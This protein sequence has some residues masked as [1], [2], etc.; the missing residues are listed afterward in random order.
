[1]LMKY[2]TFSFWGVFWVDASS[3]KTAE[4]CFS[5]VARIGQMEEKFECGLYWLSRQ[6][7]PWLLV[8]DG[9]NDT[10]FDYAQ[11]FPSGGMGHILVTSRNP[12]CKVHA[13]IGS[14]EFASLEENDAISLLLRSASVGDLSD[15]QLRGSARPIAKALGYLPLALIQA[16]AAIQQ[17][18]CSLEEYLDIFNLYKRKTFSTELQQGKSSYR[19]DIFTTFEVS[20]DKIRSFRTEE[21]K[22]ALEILHVM[23][24]LHFDQVPEALFERAWD[25]L[26]H[27]SELFDTLTDKV[28][29]VPGDLATVSSAYGGWL[30]FLAEGRLPQIFS[31]PGSKWDKLRFRKAIHVLRSYSLIFRNV[32][33]NNYSMHPMVQFWARERLRPKAQKLWGNM[34]S[35]LLAES[36][37]TNTKESKESDVVYRRLLM[38]HIDSCLKVDYCE[39]RQGLDFDDASLSQYAKF[40]AVYAECGRWIEAA[41]IQE[42]ILQNRRSTLDKDSLEAVDIMTDLARS[43]WNSSQGQKALKLQTALLELFNLKLGPDDPRTLQA[44][45]SLGRTHWLCGSTSQAD[46]LGRQSYEGLTKVVGADHPFTLSAMHNYGRARLHLSDSKMAQELLMEAWEGRSRLLGET[47]LDTLETMQDLGMSCLALKQI[48]EA[49]HLVSFVLDARKRILGQEHAHTLWSI[50]DLSKIYCAQGYASDAVSLLIPTREIAS[51]TLGTTHIGTIMTIFNLSQAYTQLHKFDQ[52]ETIL[53]ELLETEEKYIGPGHPDVFSAK[54]ALAK[55]CKQRGNMRRAETLFREAFEG[56]SAVFGPNNPRTL[57]AK[58]QL[59]EIS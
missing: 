52:A 15:E 47:H 12:E 19:L 55:V 59:L 36:I 45:D 29:R 54:L 9:A 57:Q 39:S 14:E 24:F 37:T 30:T 16:G 44:M 17:N 34:A 3:H 51:R 4:Q 43:Y 1:M 40:A 10:K 20:F 53:S 33:A 11:Y 41:T 56:R 22:D 49:D 7:M 48:D 2:N 28:A 58:M 46:K 8:I 38:P 6:E 18:I 32:G 21:A 50:N 27:G 42:K 5:D 35:R 23:A 31:Q 13:T 26:S 25:S